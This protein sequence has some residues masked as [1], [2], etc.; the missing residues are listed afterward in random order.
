MALELR[1][2]DKRLIVILEE[3]KTIKEAYEKWTQFQV[4]RFS[5]RIAD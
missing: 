2:F 1:K 4:G 5:V 3:G